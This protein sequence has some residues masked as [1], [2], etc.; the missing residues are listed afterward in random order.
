MD[1]LLDAE[2]ETGGTPFDEVERGLCLEGGD[3][4]GAVAGDDVAAVEEGDGHV[5]AVAGV[6]DDH[7]VVGLEALEG[8]IVDPEALVRALA[9]GDDGGVADERVV[10]ARIGHEVGLELVEVDV[11]RA[12]EPEAGRDGA[13]HLGDQAV[14]VVVV[15]ARDVE[16]PAADVVHGLVVD[17]KGAVRVLDGA[18]GGQHGVVGLDHG[19]GDARGRVDGELELGFLAVF[20]GQALEQERAEAGAGAATEGVA[21]DE[22]LEGGA[23]VWW[24]WS[25]SEWRAGD[26]RWI[27]YGYRDWYLQHGGRGR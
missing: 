23:V 10:D 27:G 16:V 20:G 12:V 5:L 15:R 25:E 2:F 18:V 6:A 7:L 1:Y 22:A 9:L 8:Q 24:W 4:G 13:D 11:E 21:D 17:Q 19:G 26:G 3:G 14:E